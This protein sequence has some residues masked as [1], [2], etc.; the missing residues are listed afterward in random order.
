[1]DVDGTMVDDGRSSSPVGGVVI[2][3]VAIA[4]VAGL[5]YGYILGEGQR[6]DSEAAP[7]TVPDTSMSGSTTTV[8]PLTSVATSLFEEI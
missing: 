3:L 4:V 5:V 7:V 2:A 6:V 8:P 1:M